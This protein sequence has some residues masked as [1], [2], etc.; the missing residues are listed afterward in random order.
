M[1]TNEQKTHLHLLA[2]ASLSLLRPGLSPELEEMAAEIEPR[3]ERGVSDKYQRARAQLAQTG[4]TA[5]DTVKL[6]SLIDLGRSLFH[7]HVGTAIELRDRPNAT[8]VVDMLK[9]A[10]V[11]GWEMID[12]AVSYEEQMELTRLKGISL[13]DL[14]DETTVRENRIAA[15]ERQVT[16]AKDAS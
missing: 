8:F 5:D 11:I 2:L 10:R 1:I 12:L 4:V 13:I 16:Y 14:R 15:L 9:T 7:I 3:G 6:A